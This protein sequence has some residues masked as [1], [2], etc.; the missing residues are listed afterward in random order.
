MNTWLGLWLL[1]FRVLCFEPNLGNHLFDAVFVDAQERHHA[2]NMAS[3]N[4]GIPGASVPD[5]KILI[6]FCSL[7]I[8]PVMM[9]LL[10]PSATRRAMVEHCEDGA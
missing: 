4:L 8:D 2:D 1:V 6:R 5:G 9:K 7:V 3:L 10:V